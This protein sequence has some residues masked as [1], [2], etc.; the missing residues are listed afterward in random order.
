[1]FF[2]HELPFFEYD[3]DYTI[4]ASIYIYDNFGNYIDNKLYIIEPED[5]KIV[6]YHNLIPDVNRFYFVR[7]TLYPKT[8]A[9][10]KEYLL[11]C[12][13]SFREVPNYNTSEETYVFS[14]EYYITKN[15]LRKGIIERLFAGTSET[16]IYPV[17]ENIRFGSGV[18]NE[19]S[20]K[21]TLICKPQL[22]Y[23]NVYKLNTRFLK[24]IKEDVIHNNLGIV[25]SNEPLKELEC[26]FEIQ[27]SI[28]DND[29]RL[30]DVN[31]RINSVDFC[32]KKYGKEEFLFSNSYS[33][34]INGYD[35]MA[36][37]TE[38]AVNVGN[39]T[40][41]YQVDDTVKQLFH[42]SDS[43]SEK[44]KPA[45]IPEITL[46]AGI[47]IITNEYNN[48]NVND[49]FSITENIFT[50]SSDII[51]EITKIEEIV[52][53]RKSLDF[54]DK[55][56]FKENVAKNTANLDVLVL[57][58]SSLNK[59]W[60]FVEPKLEKGRFVCKETIYPKFYE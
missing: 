44:L 13:Y 29:L 22:V 3:D 45:G 40:I 23:K 48:A 5:N 47:N 43:V 17:I 24:S 20:K 15:K 50:E 14:D 8:F 58:A 37:D 54:S 35:F 36:F 16:R 38:T 34:N 21:I 33:E 60:D 39:Y 18:I 31:G 53:A 46:D 12:E 41:F 51:N 57:E 42:T 32:L 25:I 26:T 7:Q 9:L 6:I 27:G 59:N 55:L 56:Q 52:E 19:P 2:K 10:T 1:M 30:E 11:N 4:N 49:T 28:L